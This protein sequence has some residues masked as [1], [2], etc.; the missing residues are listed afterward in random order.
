MKLEILVINEIKNTAE[1]IKKNY[2]TLV[3]MGTG[4]SF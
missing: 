4:G 2:E 3:V 1:S